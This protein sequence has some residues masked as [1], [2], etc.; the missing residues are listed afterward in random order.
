MLKSD[1]VIIYVWLRKSLLGRQQRRDR[2]QRI[3]GVG[4]GMC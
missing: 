2:I 4:E 3:A 1:K